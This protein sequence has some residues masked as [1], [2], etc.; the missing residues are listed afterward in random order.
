[1]SVAESAHHSR[2]AGCCAINLMGQHFYAFASGVLYWPSQSTL[3]VADLHL[4]KGSS[5]ARK[6]LF[7]PPYDSRA[8][9]ARLTTIVDSLTPDTIIALG[10]S[11][12]DKEGADRLCAKDHAILSAMQVGRE[13]IWIAGNHDPLPPQE[14]GGI[15][16]DELCF[17]TLIFRHEPV[18]GATGEIAGH[19]HPCA[20]VRSRARSVRR[21]CFIEDGNR[22]ILPAFG[23]LTGGLNILDSSYDGLFS[24]P[25]I[26][27]LGDEQIYSIPFKE[28]R[29][30]KKM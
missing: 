19:L 5:F 3:I 18:P 7:L 13:W 25:R 10:D 1:M 21:S 4:E 27:M 24:S 23:A 15:A 16:M 6:G 22:L 26:H 12:H 20:K 28:C 8:T 11:F 30:D 29:P 14:V 17:G 2:P 9:L